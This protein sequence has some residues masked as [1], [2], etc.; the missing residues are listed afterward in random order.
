M[1]RKKKR[2]EELIRHD[3]RLLSIKNKAKMKM[4][5]DEGSDNEKA[6]DPEKKK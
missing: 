5:E 3:R 4:S 6:Q 1:L 2:V